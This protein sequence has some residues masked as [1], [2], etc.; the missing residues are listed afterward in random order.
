MIPFGPWRPD[1]AKFD[2]AFSNVATNVVW[3]NDGYRPI[4]KL[5]TTSTSNT[6]TNV[7][8]AFSCRDTSGGVH[9]FCGDRTKLYKLN[10]TGTA[11]SDVSRSV[12]GAY[13]L[14]ADSGW[15]TFTQF[16]NFVMADNGVD[17][18]QVYQLGVSSVFA[19]LAGSPPIAKYGAIIKGFSVKAA[20]A[21]ATNRVQWS[22]L[23]NH[24][25]YSIG[26][27]S[28]A[29][30]QDFAEGGQ[31]QGIVGGEYGLV[32][33]DRAVQRMTFE[34]PPTIFRFDQI[35]NSIGCRVPRSIAGLGDLAFWFGHEGFFQCVGAQQITPIGNDKVDRWLKENISIGDFDKSVA[36]IDPVNKLYC[37]AFRDIN[38]GSSVYNNSMLL[39]HW[40]SGEWTLVRDDIGIIYPAY[41]QSGYTLDTLDAVYPDLDAMTLSLD[42]SVLQGTNQLALCCISG[43]GD[44]QFFTGSNMAANIETGVFELTPGRKSMLRGFRPMIEGTTL[45]NLQCIIRGKD[46]LHEEFLGS[47]EGGV[48]ELSTMN[49]FGIVPCRANARY[50]KITA[51]ISADNVWTHARGIDDM[52]QSIMGRR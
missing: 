44:V 4:A 14:P 26:G 15:W 34:G 23:E 36:A 16:G 1:V 51:S 27:T 47:R 52:R 5:V 29:D 45:T 40:P 17:A 39:Y 46:F 11:W 50:H 10:G 18:A 19:A 9:N 20:V 41:Q 30:Y 13:T 42:S 3:S 37:F 6:G 38:R 12:G 22:D 25:S 7:R 43:S 8:G 49:Q 2:S 33:Q 31:I 32:F 35:S 21:S 24:A 28:L 48:S